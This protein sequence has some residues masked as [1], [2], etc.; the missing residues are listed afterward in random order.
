MSNAHSD[1]YKDLKKA[2]I[3]VFERKKEDEDTFP[4]PQRYTFKDKDGKNNT[5]NL[6][7]GEDGKKVAKEGSGVLDF[8]DLATEFKKLKV[9]AKEELSDSEKNLLNRGLFE[10]IERVDCDPKK[11][12]ALLDA[13][14]DINAYNEEGLQAIHLAAVYDDSK[15]SSVLKLLI[16]RGADIE[17]KAKDGSRPIHFACFGNDKTFSCLQGK[18]VDLRAKNDLG[19]EPIHYAAAFSY[20]EKILETLLAK[21]AAD[22][23]NKDGST[24][25]HCAAINSKSLDTI[26]QNGVYSNKEN[27]LGETPESV[28]KDLGEIGKGKLEKI[29]NYS[30]KNPEQKKSEKIQPEQKISEQNQPEQKYQQNYRSSQSDNKPRDIF[31]CFKELITKLIGVIGDGN[32]ETKPLSS[33]FLVGLKNLQDRKSQNQDLGCTLKEIVNGL[34]AHHSNDGS[35]PKGLVTHGNS[36]SYGGR[37]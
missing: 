11:I 21:G 16:E 37:G 24:I 6:D 3:S 15:D 4:D 13:G 32:S 12:K 8:A 14:A 10:E 27:S 5:Y 23:K 2:F 30:N 28:L 17:S 26:L 18:G 1:L 36:N 7:S 19:N 33:K 22:A 34:K 31:S 25:S 35:D 20:D 29:K 9:A